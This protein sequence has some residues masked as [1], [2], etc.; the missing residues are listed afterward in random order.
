M[1]S[2]AHQETC[3]RHPEW[4]GIAEYMRRNLVLASSYGTSAGIKSALDQ[5][6]TLKRPQQWLIA[7]LEGALERAE[8]LHG[9]LAEW[10]EA[11]PDHP[12]KPGGRFAHL[13]LT[14]KDT[15]SHG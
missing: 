8:K 12:Y 13:P 15:P 6:R 4:H 3:D 11:A 2:R 1:K 7:Y 5:L 10:R 9:D 14:N